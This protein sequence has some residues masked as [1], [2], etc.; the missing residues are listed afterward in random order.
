MKTL[1]IGRFSRSPVLAAA[2]HWGWDAEYGIALEEVPA[3]SSPA[4]FEALRDGTIDVALT[5]PDNVLLYATTDRNP[6]GERLPLQLRRAVDGGLG[7]ALVSRPEIASTEDLSGALIAVDVLPSGFAMLLKALLSKQGVDPATVAYVEE[8]G[9]PRRAERLLDGAI[10][11][12]ILNAESRV[13]AEHSGM[14]TWATSSDISPEYPGTVIAVLGDRDIQPL[15]DMWDRATAWLLDSSQELVL[16]LLSQQEP[17]LADPAYVA[18]ATSPETG[19]RRDPGITLAQLSVLVN[20]RREAGA[21]APT[22]AD[23]QALATA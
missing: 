22:D 11:A 4:Q 13:R 16:D 5:S 9:T 17:E 7:L 18:L 2:R 14:R 10:G 6:L 15:L 23:L 1:R 21:Y 12:T 20:L 19:L 3:T 8:G